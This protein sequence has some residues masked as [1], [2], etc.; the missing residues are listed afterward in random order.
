MPKVLALDHIDA[1]G[2]DLLRARPGIDL[3]HL[4]SPTPEEIAREIPDAW[5]LLLRARTL[6][7]AH[8]RAARQLA[9]VS[10]H[11]VG[12][13][14]LPLPDLHAAGVTVAITADANAVSVAEHAMMLM[15]AL[16]R[17]ATAY[18]RATREGRFA[19]RE[20]QEARDLHES[21]LLILGLGRIGRRVAHRARAFGMTVLGF[22]PAIT[23][24]AEGV[25]FVPDLDAALGRADIVTLHLPRTAATAGLFDAARLR[26]CKPG[27]ILI[28]A[29]R[30]GLVDEAALV[31]AL[32][33]GTLSGA[34]L[35]V[36]EREPVPPDHPLLRRDDVLLS[37]HSAAMTRQG[38]QR[39]AAGAAENI[40]AF[41]D[42]RLDPAMVVRPPA[43]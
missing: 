30:G 37:P 22:D 4:P 19:F 7:P 33:A 34:G 40:I 11:G 32:D 38:A 25:E 27:A 8:W 29:A 35:D 17:R 26:R 2:L 16:S 1:A 24:P 31:E 43:P 28:N 39:M 10:R 23:A 36:F 13:D 5:A 20:T 14:N 21:T 3:V 42:G 9:L 15:L 18:D 6:D 41:L 12:C